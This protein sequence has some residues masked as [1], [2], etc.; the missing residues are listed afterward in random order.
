[1]ACID[2]AYLDFR[3]RLHGI[4]QLPEKDALHE[5]A[6]ALLQERLSALP[7][8]D[9][10]S[11]RGFDNWHAAT[12]RQLCAL[13]RDAEYELFV[14]GHAQRWLNTSIKYVYTLGEERL[15]DYGPVYPLCHVPLDNTVLA[16]LERF[17]YPGLSDIWS[18]IDDY[19]EYLRCQ[20]WIRQ[21]FRVVPLDM[22]FLLRMGRA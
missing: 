11:Q 5:R 13:Y 21:R 4:N 14:L 15:P 2:R 17:G 10:M 1:M 6:C 18:R 12:C 7:Q 3:R 16:H 19:D 20:T 8:L 9:D 22:D